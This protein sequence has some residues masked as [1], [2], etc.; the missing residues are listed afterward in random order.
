MT[1]R[2][3]EGGHPSMSLIAQAITATTGQFVTKWVLLVEVIGPNG[4]QSLELY[5]DNTTQRWDRMGML[6]YALELEKIRAHR[7]TPQ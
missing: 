7:A 2:P 5:R 4:V 1:D 3:L 6:A